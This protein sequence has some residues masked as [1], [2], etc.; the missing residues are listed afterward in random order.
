K[1]YCKMWESEG[2]PVGILQ[3]VHGISEHLERYDHFATWMTQR[4]F[5]VVANDHMGHGRTVRDGHLMGH[6][7]G[8]WA[9]AVDDVEAVHQRI[10]QAFPE[11]P[12]IILGHSMGSFLTRTLLFRHPNHG[13][14]GA[15]LSGTGWMPTGI[16]Q[17]G[18]RVC[19]HEIARKTAMGRSPI[20]QKLMFGSFNLPFAPARTP[21]DWISTDS[22]VVDGFV[23]DPLC[24]ILPTLGLIEALI[25]GFEINQK[26]D[27]L[28]VMQTDL[29]ILFLSGESDP[30]G[31]MGYGVRL[32]AQRFKEAGMV[33]VITKLYPGFRHEILNETCKMEI[34]DYIL[35]WISDVIKM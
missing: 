20:L 2:Q 18:S 25:C 1:L 27:N 7:Y 17:V 16:L 30:V 21:Y 29:P 15:I 6:F 31:E 26:M 28:R 32:T 3:I 19:R 13:L 4:G 35:H 5:L 12:Y 9:A 33:K 24:G 22:A 10:A 34:Y 23:T 14:S 11:V 8:G